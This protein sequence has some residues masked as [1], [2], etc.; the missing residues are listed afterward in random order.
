MTL[1]DPLRNRLAE[2]IAATLPELEEHPVSGHLNL[3]RVTAQAQEDVHALLQAAVSSA[4]TAGHSWEAIGQVLGMTRQ[5]AHQRFGKGPAAPDSERQVR[6]VTPLTASTEIDT[7]NQLG[8]YGWHSVGFGPLYHDVRH[9][10]E[11]WEHCR[12]MAFD[13]ARRA[14]ERE[15]WRLIGTL[16]FPWAYLTRPVGQPALPMPSPEVDLRLLALRRP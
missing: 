14:L 5:A 8:R 15:G 10:G 13:P 12:V 2:T 9:S 1:D 16:W 7:L 4:R 3:I 11:Q 6:R